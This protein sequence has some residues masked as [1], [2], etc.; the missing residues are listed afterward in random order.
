MK[1]MTKTAL[2]LAA[3]GFSAWVITAQDTGNDPSQNQPPPR[4]QGPGGPGPRGHRPPPPIIAALDAN[5]DGVI[6]A[7]EIA[8]AP[9]ALL[10][11]D[12]NGDG[13]LTMD[14]LMPPRP[15][16]G[17]GPDG[18]PGPPPDDGNGK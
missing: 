2:A 18:P 10:T 3:L 12:K 14:E 7:S 16:R 17:E 6:D 1:T 4:R 5:H 15:P 13:K 8:N 9:A 11:L